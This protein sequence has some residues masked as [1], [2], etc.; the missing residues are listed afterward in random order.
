MRLG[1]AGA[2]LA[3]LCRGRDGGERG[4]TPGGRGPSCTRVLQAF[5]LRVAV[6]LLKSKV[7]CSVMRVVCDGESHALSDTSHTHS[8]TT[9]RTGRREGL[10]ITRLETRT[11]ESTVCAS[12]SV[13]KALSRSESKIVGRS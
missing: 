8:L 6:E 13:V 7:R 2:P 9:S 1:D 12:V 10:T 11:K 4:G 3:G 5:F